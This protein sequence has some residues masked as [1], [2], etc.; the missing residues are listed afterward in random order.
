MKR[1]AGGGDKSQIIGFLMFESK[2]AF[3][4][5]HAEVNALPN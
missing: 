1:E 2:R 5:I 3:F 4:L